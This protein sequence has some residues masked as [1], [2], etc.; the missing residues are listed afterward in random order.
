[1]SATISRLFSV[2]RNADSDDWYTP[3][4]VFDGMGVIFDMDV[5]APP[6][7][8]AWVPAVRSLSESDDGLLTPWAGYVWCNPPYSAPTQWCRKWAAHEPGGCILIRS[9]L[10]TSGPFAAF[11]AAD[12][13]YFAP[14]RLQFVNGRGGKTGAVNFSTVILARGRVCVDGLH[15]LAASAGGAA[16]NLVTEQSS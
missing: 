15:R 8:V 16:R 13:A 3:Q 5:A 1:V 14:K 9:D 10:S 2:E 7:G 6:G 4:W 12:A 11:S